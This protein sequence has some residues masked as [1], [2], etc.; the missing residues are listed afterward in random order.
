[1]N[2]RLCFLLVLGLLS[3]VF[4][5]AFA[6]D[7]FQSLAEAYQMEGLDRFVGQQAAAVLKEELAEKITEWVQEET[8]DRGPKT[9][10]QKQKLK[11]NIKAKI[12]EWLPKAAKKILEE[13]VLAGNT[14][15]KEMEQEITAALNRSINDNIDHWIGDFYD[16]R[17]APFLQRVSPQALL[18]RSGFA[19]YLAHQM[20]EA[21]GKST[22]SGMQNGI[23]KGLNGHLPDEALE[24]LKMGPEKFQE[25]SAKLKNYL[26][27]SQFAKLKD[28]VMGIHLVDLPNQVYGG[29]LA[30]SAAMHMA[31]FASSCSGWGATCNWNELKRF[32]EVTET[33]IWQLRSKQSVTMNLGDFVGMMK[34]LGDQLGDLNWS[35]LPQIAK[36]N[37]ANQ[38]LEKLDW[39]EGELKKIDAL[40]DQATGK[41]LDGFDKAIADIEGEL[42]KMSAE[43]LAP[44]KQKLPCLLAEGCPD[45]LADFPDITSWEGL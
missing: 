20:G 17:I 37:P 5:P 11:E 25:Y 2:V 32:K 18:Q 24:Y 1:M 33:T 13:K 42:K 15:L 36:W 22:V 44:L 16:S 30:A 29:V 21:I 6:D 19:D 40:Y 26:P 7:D 45:F 43:L 23:L 12:K 9:E 14:E 31:K 41:V 35:A 4:C 10:D 39:V 38:F 3:S 28:K 34:R 8:E 27:S